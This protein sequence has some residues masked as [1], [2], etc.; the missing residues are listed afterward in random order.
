MFPFF[1]SQGISPPSCDSSSIM[2]HG[3]AATSATSFRILG[4]IPS[5]PTDL[6][7]SRSSF[8]VERI[9]LF[10]VHPQERYGKRGCHSFLLWQEKIDYFILHPLLSV[11]QS[12]FSGGNTSFDLF[13]VC[14]NLSYYS[15]HPLLCS[16]PAAPCHSW[17]HPYKTR[18]LPRISSIP[19]SNLSLCLLCCLHTQQKSVHAPKIWELMEKLLSLLA[20]PLSLGAISLPPPRDVGRDNEFI[21]LSFKIVC[22]TAPKCILKKKKKTNQQSPEH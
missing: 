3:L 7:R 21:N 2:E 10:I 19:G 15:L 16:A 1:L 20:K 12:C 17:S 11:F 18:Q 9:F 14:K 4:C 8:I 22:L 5:G 13:L 6:Q